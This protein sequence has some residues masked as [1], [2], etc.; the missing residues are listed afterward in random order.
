MS[1]APLTFA[2]LFDRLRDEIAARHLTQREAAEQIGVSARTLQ[3]WLDGQDVIPRP[4]HR[5][6]L[7]VW[8]ERSREDVLS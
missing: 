8:L 1:T 7:I 5:R 2:D 3:Y 4:A 6:A